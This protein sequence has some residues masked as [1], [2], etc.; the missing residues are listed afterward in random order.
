MLDFLKNYDNL[1]VSE[2]KV[3][4][5]LTDNIADIPYL[6]I[7]DLVAKTFVSK[8][9]I[10]NLSQ[11]LGFSGFKELKFQINNYILSRNKIEKS[12][13]S[14]YKKQLEKNINKSF[15]LINEEQIKEC[16]KTLRHSRNI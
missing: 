2:K 6:N 3:L 11:K 13:H 14:S 16:A 5:Y 1:T 15:T 7:N 8:T 10:I 4:K 12:D 9:V